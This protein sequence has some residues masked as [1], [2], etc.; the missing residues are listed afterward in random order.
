MA[1]PRI[2]PTRLQRTVAD[3]EFG[4]DFDSF[5][6]LC[7]AVAET[8]WAKNLSLSVEMCGQLIIAHET[9]TKVSKPE[10]YG[11]SDNEPEEPSP[12]PTAKKKAKRGKTCPGCQE[13]IG[14]RSRKCKHCGFDFD[15]YNAETSLMDQPETKDEPEPAATAKPTPAPAASKPPRSTG[16]VK[17]RSVS[18]TMLRIHTPAGSCPH[19]LEDTDEATVQRWAEK[20]RD[21][22]ESDGRFYSLPALKYYARQF[23][24]IFSDE[25]KTVVGHLQ[26]L[27]GHEI[28]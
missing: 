21:T 12:P 25:W 2:F 1:L 5:D 17:H 18:A 23:Y 14:A 4:T 19:R 6:A 8:D 3:L 10:S 7:E 20:V 26:A 9:I 11:S 13:V 28:G 24:D 15:N 16:S 27:Y 22:G